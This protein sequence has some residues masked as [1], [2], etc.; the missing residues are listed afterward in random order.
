MKAQ[1][2]EAGYSVVFS[3]P[4]PLAK[5]GRSRVGRRLAI[6]VR[7]P[8]IPALL[9]TVDD[10]SCA[11]LLHSGRWIECFAPTDDGSKHLGAANLYGYAG[12]STDDQLRKLNELLLKAAYSRMASFNDVPYYIGMDQCK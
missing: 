12:A 8:G 5:D 11:Y 4:V 6:F 10:K 1:A 9:A 7:L 3:L 2:L